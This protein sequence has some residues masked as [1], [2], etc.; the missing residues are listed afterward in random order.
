MRKILLG[1]MILSMVLVSACGK[2]PAQTEN[3]A[4]ADVE[5]FLRGENPELMELFDGQE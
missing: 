1:M 4:E 3:G 2:Q 5:A